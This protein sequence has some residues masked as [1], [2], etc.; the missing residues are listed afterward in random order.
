MDSLCH[1]LLKQVRHLDGA[2]RALSPASSQGSLS[3]LAGALGGDASMQPE[4]DTSSPKPARR[5]VGGLRE[6][7]GCCPRLGAV[8]VR[9]PSGRWSMRPSEDLPMPSAP[10]AVSSFATPLLLRHPTPHHPTPP[11]PAGPKGGAAR[12]RGSGGGGGGHPG[13][14]P[15]GHRQLDSGTLLNRPT[16]GLWPSRYK[17]CRCLHCTPSSPTLY[18][19]P[20]PNPNPPCPAAGSRHH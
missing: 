5:L 8:C 20:S 13:D 10:F 1:A 19:N 15:S 2:E 12:L 11:P 17:M 14:Q 3:Q 7:R 9:W 16:A 4:A 6:V 18:P